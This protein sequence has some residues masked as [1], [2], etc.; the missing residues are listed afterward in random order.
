M[1][2]TQKRDQILYIGHEQK[3]N[4]ISGSSSV[5][6][7]TIVC[8]FMST[9]DGCGRIVHKCLSGICNMKGD[10]AYVKTLS[11]T[12]WFVLKNILCF[13]VDLSVLSRL[14]EKPGTQCGVC[15]HM[16]S[17]N[18]QGDDSC[19]IKKWYKEI[20]RMSYC[21]LFLLLHKKKKILV[22]QHGKWGMFQKIYSMQ[23]SMDPYDYLCLLQCLVML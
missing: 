23:K 9:E 11:K 2:S 3:F 4:E 15:I 7:C 22:K 14:A 12:I 18:M 20:N 10:S 13:H 5:W 19:G 21:M 8:T 1:R 17:E 16:E 6:K